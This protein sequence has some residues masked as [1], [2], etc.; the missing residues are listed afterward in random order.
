MAPRCA[1]HA[2][3]LPAH[4]A[5][6]TFVNV[7]MHTICDENANRIEW[8][9]VPVRVPTANQPGTVGVVVCQSFSGMYE[10]NVEFTVDLTCEFI[11]EGTYAVTPFINASRGSDVYPFTG[12]ALMTIVRPAPATDTT[13]PRLDVMDMPAGIPK[14]GSFAVHVRI[15][16]TN[17]DWHAYNGTSYVVA[18]NATRT[19]RQFPSPSLET[20]GCGT[21]RQLVTPLY[22]PPP[23]N[24]TNATSPSP[25]PNVS[26]YPPGT[27]APPSSAPN[28]VGPQAPP[29]PAPDQPYPRP[30][31]GHE[32]DT[33][34]P[35]FHP[36]YDVTVQCHGPV[37][38]TYL[39][40]FARFPGHNV[41]GEE[42]R[43]NA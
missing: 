26:G 25:S 33:S 5:P 4:V 32:A 22:A 38:V 35:T 40:P 13:V 36:V 10:A 30:Q 23:A 9:L 43:V 17:V 16:W 19:P 11:D 24:A 3:G 7:T 31:P 18:V 2:S 27:Y 20:P 28:S 29:P 39:R 6:Y 1:I 8:K 41:W 34:G 21:A 37:P 15:D 42:I 12:P 14:N